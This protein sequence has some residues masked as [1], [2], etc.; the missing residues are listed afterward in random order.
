MH[1]TAAALVSILA[2]AGFSH[3]APARHGSTSPGRNPSSGGESSS[4][5]TG[6]IHESNIPVTASSALEDYSTDPMLEFFNV[7]RKALYKIT[8]STVTLSEAQIFKDAEANYKL[9]NDGVVPS[10]HPLVS[11]VNSHELGYDISAMNPQPSAKDGPEFVTKFVQLAEKV[12]PRW[13]S[14]IYN[15]R[16]KHRGEQTDVV[17]RPN[18]NQ[19]PTSLIHA[20]DV[21][22]VLLKYVQWKKAGGKISGA[23]LPPLHAAQN[24]GATYGVR[25]RGQDGKPVST[26]GEVL[27][28][29]QQVDPTCTQGQTELGE[30]HWF[31]K[32]DVPE[33][34]RP[35]KT[36]TN[37]SPAGAGDKRPI[38]DV[39]QNSGNPN[40]RKAQ[41]KGDA[42]APE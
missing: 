25:D 42:A 26:C 16:E 15:P 38:A 35:G 6:A 4:A 7:N 11:F 5:A 30:I 12:A 29:A 19:R 17:Q 13:I 34:V 40:V 1:L 2:L 28:G 32:N 18:P 14:I 23:D 24:L 36:T 41:R 3:A 8:R 37:A 20:E 22:Y 33:S 21:A 9:F 31:S 39:R 10:M 27:N